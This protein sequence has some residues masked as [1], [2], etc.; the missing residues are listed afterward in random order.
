[1]LPDGF[2]WCA[3]MQHDDG[4]R[5]VKLHGREVARLSRKVNG[6]WFALLRPYLEVFSPYVARDCTSF[7]SGRAVVEAW[8]RRHEA[9]LR[10]QAAIR[11]KAP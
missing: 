4:E 9:H 1:M 2:E 6:E 10:E 3:V 11:A 7:E 8:V 5:A